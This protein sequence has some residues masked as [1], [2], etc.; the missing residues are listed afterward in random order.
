MGLE[1]NSLQL[2]HT[3]EGSLV[4]SLKREKGMKKISRIFTKENLKMT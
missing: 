1:K 4:T 3:I 2:E